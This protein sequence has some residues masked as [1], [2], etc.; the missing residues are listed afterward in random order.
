[1]DEIGSTSLIGMLE[2]CLMA[3]ITLQVAITDK[4]RLLQSPPSSTLGSKPR[5]TV[6]LED[7]LDSSSLMAPPF[8]ALIK[9]LSLT[10]RG[11]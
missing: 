9:G 2:A 11:I 1:M 5:F 8:E 3:V 10:D 6:Q 7:L 4:T